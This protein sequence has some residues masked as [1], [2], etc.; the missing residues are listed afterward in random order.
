MTKRERWARRDSSKRVCHPPSFV[1][2][3]KKFRHGA[4][5][6]NIEGR[7]PNGFVSTE[8]CCEPFDGAWQQFPQAAKQLGDNKSCIEV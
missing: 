5:V 2:W 7:M 6:L 3:R 1:S 8:Q 4:Q